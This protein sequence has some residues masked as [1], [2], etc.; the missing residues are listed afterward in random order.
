MPLLS[1]IGADSARGYGLFGLQTG[2]WIGLLGTPA[3]GYSVAVDSVGNVYLCGTT[4]NGIGTIK[5]NTSGVIQWQRSL[6]GGFNH[7]GQ[8]IAVGSTGNVYVSGYSYDGTYYNLQIIK[9]NASGVI[10][11]QKNL[12]GVSYNSYGYSIIDPIPIRSIT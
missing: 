3:D 1:T 6:S 10:Q 12:T 7:Y 2:Y 8:G 11:F 5:C 4:S 9:Y